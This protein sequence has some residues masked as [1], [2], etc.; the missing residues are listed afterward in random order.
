M[1]DACQPPAVLLKLR[2][3]CRHLISDRTARE[4]PSVLPWHCVTND[5]TFVILV[6]AHLILDSP[7]MYSLLRSFLAHVVEYAVL[8]SSMVSQLVNANQEPLMSGVTIPVPKFGQTAR[9]DAWWLQPLLVLPRSLHLSSTPPGRHYRA[10]ITPGGPTCR[11]FTRRRFLALPR[12][13]GSAQ[14]RLVAR[15]VAVLSCPADSVGSRGVSPHLLL[16]SRSVL[17]SLLGRSSLLHRRRAAKVYRGENSFPL[18]LQNIHRYFLYL[19]LLFL[20]VLAGMSGK[21]CGSW[22]P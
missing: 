14:A 15:L 3:N 12:I 7:V 2:C 11:L 22:I 1:N 20:I 10:T 5:A 19:A 21:P 9:R 4:S 17:Q 8:S 13:V 16:L 18:I 6:R